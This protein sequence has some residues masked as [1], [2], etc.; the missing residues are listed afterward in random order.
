MNINEINNVLTEKVHR[1]N[2]LSCKKNISKK[3]LEQFYKEIEPDLEQLTYFMPQVYFNMDNEDSSEFLLFMIPKFRSIIS[4]FNSDRN[5]FCAFFYS[6]LKTKTKSFNV[7]K[8]QNYVREDLVLNSFEVAD[9]VLQA[10]YTAK[11]SQS[12][13][14]SD[15]T[16]IKNSS[17]E[18][19]RLRYALKHSITI[20]RRFFVYILSI[21]PFLDAM[22][23][24]DISVLGRYN[25]PQVMVLTGFL[26]AKCKSIIETKEKLIESRNLCFTRKLEIQRDLRNMNLSGYGIKRTQEFL[27][28]LNEKIDRKNFQI[29]NFP[30]HVP[31]QDLAD[32]LHVNKNTVS[33]QIFYARKFISWCCQKKLDIESNIFDFAVGSALVRDLILGRWR[34]ENIDKDFREFL[35]IEEFGI[36]IGIDTKQ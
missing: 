33:T 18:M 10:N 23:L 20:R 31:Y 6:V 5:D 13:P 36:D 19:K 14:L 26:T 7:S 30:N 29:D 16:F 8:A 21:C 17:D 27:D 34:N 15:K 9:S 1:F 2:M 11:M 35:P 25:Y 28:S 22:T 4:K 12:V 3:K 24:S 32:L